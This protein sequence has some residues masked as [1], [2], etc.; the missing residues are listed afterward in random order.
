M[1]DYRDRVNEV[2]ADCV[3]LLSGRTPLLLLRA[4]A[5]AN[6]D[7]SATDRVAEIDVEPLVADDPGLFGIDAEVAGGIL[8]HAWER[9]SAAAIDGELGNGAARMMAAEVQGVEIGAAALQ[10]PPH[11]VMANL[12]ETG[13]DQPMRDAGLIRDDDQRE[14]GALEQPQ[15]I[16]G[17]R[18]QLEVLEPM[19]V[20]DVNVERPITI[21]EDGSLHVR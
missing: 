21:E 15:R 14:A 9:F 2:V 5:G 7:R 13:I 17:P 11:L 12:H 18:E 4:P 16:R 1:K 10:P 6:Q 3:D 19:Q 8:D 20:A